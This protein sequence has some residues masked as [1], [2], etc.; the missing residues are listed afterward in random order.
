ML[1]LAGCAGAMSG[2]DGASPEAV[3]GGDSA[4][5]AAGGGGG[6]AGG[7]SDGERAEAQQFDGGDVATQGRMVI[8]TGQM[9]LTVDD[10]DQART[11]LATM[12]RDRG[13]Y[14]S[15]TT[16]Q[17]HRRNNVT[18]TTGRVVLRVPSDEFEGSF[19]EAKELGTVESSSTD[20]EDVT[21]QLVDIEARLENLR[22]ERDRLRT[23]YEEAN[24]TEDVLRVSREL[25]DVQ[26]EIERLE[27]RQRQLESRVQLSTITVELDE[28]P[29]EEPRPGPEAWWETSV[30]SAFLESVSGVVTV[31]RALVVGTAY[32]L[33]YVLA[34]GTPFVLAGALAWR[35]LSG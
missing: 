22:A 11:S 5:A 34:F 29:D 8:R 18:W 13:G 9:T 24:E 26:E 1:V 15:D 6:D 21:D 16:Q 33:P 14:V 3:D 28:Q 27:A 20:S 25:S 17:T 2:S 7:E 19:E 31:V 12:A 4:G 35:R 30:V 32:V 23:L 10:Y